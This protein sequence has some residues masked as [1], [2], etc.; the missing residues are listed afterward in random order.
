MVSVKY[1]ISEIESNEEEVKKLE[2]VIY[3]NKSQLKDLCIDF[4]LWV[5]KKVPEKYERKIF[6]FLYNG[7]SIE[8]GY[9]TYYATLPTKKEVGNMKWFLGDRFN[10]H[11]EHYTILSEN[12]K[13]YLYVDI[14]KTE[15]DD[16]DHCY[17]KDEVGQ[18][19]LPIHYIERLYYMN[20][21]EDENVVRMNKEEL[22]KWIQERVE[23]MEKFIEEEKLKE[24]ENAKK[25]EEEKKKELEEK[26][27]QEYLRLKGKYE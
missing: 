24:Q 27:Y 17:S 7:V 14:E 12:D 18:F 8:K 23:Y 10:I 11:I 3:S 2:D 22:D 19:V 6:S 26:E 16:Y 1:L 9:N 20:N 13:E 5:M 15:Y 25:R 4:I 21:V